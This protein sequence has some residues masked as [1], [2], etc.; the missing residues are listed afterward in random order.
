MPHSLPPLYAL[1]AFEAAANYGSF[2][3]AALSLNLTPGAISRHVK[4]LEQWFGRPLF[5]RRGP[6][7]EATPAAR[8]FARQLQQ[9]FGQIEHACR[10]FQHQQ[11]A[12]RLKAPS[13]LTTRWLLEVLQHFHQQ[14]AH[15][16]VH[17]TSVWMDVDHIDFR[18]EPFDCAILLGNGH[19]G[20][21][22]QSTL[23]FA[24]WL[25]PVCAPSL[26]ES[27]RHQ[28]AECTALHPS[29]D[30]RDWRRW[31]QAVYPSHPPRLGRSVVFDTLEQGTQA[32][33]FGHGITIADWFLTRPAIENHLLALPFPEAVA[34]G[35]GYYLV[36]PTNSPL[37][38]LLAPLE[39][40]LLHAAPADFPADMTLHGH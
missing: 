38:S 12:L 31:L 17:V 24:E 29:A 36:Y 33:L 26:L 16:Q 19:F 8:E 34:T 28:L 23:L 39:Q 3:Q 21:G 18:H 1:R 15:P 7:V 2:S 11:N 22:T 35:D 4:T 40:A 14:P 27:A 32:A 10:H 20:A 37:A 6:T 30:G 9:G 25:I 5:L 13:T